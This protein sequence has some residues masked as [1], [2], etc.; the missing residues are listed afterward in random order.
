MRKLSEMEHLYQPQELMKGD[1]MLTVGA[2]TEFVSSD[3][4]R[5]G[6]EST[7]I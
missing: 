6:I 7:P 2:A 3:P 5:E 1:R 4:D